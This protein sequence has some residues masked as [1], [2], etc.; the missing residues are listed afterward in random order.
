MLQIEAQPLEHNVGFWHSPTFG[1]VATRSLSAAKP[2]WPTR[3]GN[4]APDPTTDMLSKDG[5]YLMV[6]IGRLTALPAANKSAGGLKQQI[7]DGWGWRGELPGC[8][9]PYWRVMPHRFAVTLLSQHP[10]D[11]QLSNSSRQT[12]LHLGPGLR[13][14]Q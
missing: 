3:L 7:A 5:S 8:H 4:V 14:S 12:G 9:R 10:V 1:N 13:L 6:G 2:T 11:M